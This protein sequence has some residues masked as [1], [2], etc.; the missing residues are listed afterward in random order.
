[1]NKQL[2]KVHDFSA[3]RA[4][5]LLLQRGLTNRVIAQ[6]IGCHHIYVSKMV[7]GVAECRGKCYN[8]RAGSTYGR[9]CDFLK[10][11]KCS[12]VVEHLNLVTMRN[13]KGRVVSLG[14]LSL[15]RRKGG[16]K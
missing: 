13:S 8:L 1:M 3:H 10:S 11:R 4:R 12:D 7:N 9:F 6:A 14:E 15:S 2:K 16:R 5:E